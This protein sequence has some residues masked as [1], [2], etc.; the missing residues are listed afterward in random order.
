[1]NKDDAVLVYDGYCNLCGAIV[2]FLKRHDRR[3]RFSYV[4]L[5]SELG[6]EIAV[7]AG[8]EAGNISTVILFH[9]SEYYIRSTAALRVFRLLGGGWKLLY[10]FIIVPRFIRDFIYNMVARTRYLIFGRNKTCYIP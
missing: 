5:Q 2:R 7:A 10:G 6:R 8:L 4:P 3:G 1:V 9:D